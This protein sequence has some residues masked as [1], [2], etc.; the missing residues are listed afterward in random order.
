M[1]ITHEA[2]VRQPEFRWAGREV[3]RE[4]NDRPHLLLRVEITG[5][6]FPLR[7]APAFVRIVRESGQVAESWFAEASEDGTTLVGYF[8]PGTDA[9]GIVEFGYGNK[10]MGRVSQPF[11]ARGVERLDRA[12]LPRE[13]VEPREMPVQSRQ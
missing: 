9:E 13:V 2:F 7:D 5:A 8:P 1:S 10:V 11:T 6:F 4:L 12:R 3:V